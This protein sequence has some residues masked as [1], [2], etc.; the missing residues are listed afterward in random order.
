MLYITDILGPCL[1]V[2]SVR[3]YP[4]V[5]PGQ[6]RSF[7][8]VGHPHQSPQDCVCRVPLLNDLIAWP[9]LPD[10]ALVVGRLAQGLPVHLPRGSVPIRPH[11]HQSA[12]TP[13]NRVSTIKSKF[14]RLLY[15]LYLLYYNFSIGRVSGVVE[16]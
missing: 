15:L 13:S 3:L 2:L 8:A 14:Y 11:R 12:P 7:A 16:K 1:F 6:Y 5:G 9:Q 10:V 4:T